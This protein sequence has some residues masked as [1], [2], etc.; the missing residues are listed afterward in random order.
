MFRRA[1][2][3][4]FISSLYLG[5]EEVELVRTREYTRF[6]VQHTRV[7]THVFVVSQVEVLRHSLRENPS[8]ILRMHLDLNRSTRPGPDSPA[9]TLL[10]LLNEFPDRV[11]ISLFRSPKLKGVLAKLVPPRFNEGWGTWHPKIYG[12]DDEVLISG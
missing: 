5:S 9:H 2:R 11:R 7:L 4:I 12:V 3:R 8:L 10:P 1:R 6:D